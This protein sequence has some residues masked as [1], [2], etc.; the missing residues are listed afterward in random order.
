MKFLRAVCTLLLLVPTVLAGRAAINQF[1]KYQEWGGEYFTPFHTFNIVA[2]TLLAV[3]LLVLALC[4]ALDHEES[5]EK[6]WISLGD[7]LRSVF[8]ATAGVIAIGVGWYETEVQDGSAWP[9]RHLHAYHNGDIAVVWGVGTALILLSIY[10]LMRSRASES[11]VGGQTTDQAPVGANDWPDDDDF[12]VEIT[13]NS[14][15][16][17]TVA[18]RGTYP[19]IE[20]IE[21]L[22]DLLA[23]REL[24]NSGH[25]F[26]HALAGDPFGNA[27]GPQGMVRVWVVSPDGEVDVP[28]GDYARDKS[29]QP[30]DEAAP[31]APQS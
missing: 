17:T 24:A 31:E 1:E 16:E 4:V 26:G 3:A 7:Y 12:E 27:F 11:R 19:S 28:A 20:Q 15:H 18:L 30:G 9:Y 29:P 25:P 10:Y 6:M 14:D 5:P 2:L 8:L 13:H 22:L 21:G 23:L